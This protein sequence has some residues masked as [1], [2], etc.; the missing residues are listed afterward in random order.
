MVKKTLNSFKN[1]E[2]VHQCSRCGY[3]QAVCPVFDAVRSELAVARGKISLVKALLSGELE[4]TPTLAKYIE[5]CTGCGAC[6]ESCL[7]GVSVENI[8]LEARQHIAETLGLSLPKKAIVTAFNDDKALSF[9]SVLLN[10]YSFS[11]AGFAADLVPSQTP[12]LDKVKLLNAQLEKFNTNKHSLN[13][14]HLKKKSPLASYVYFPGCINKY[15]NPSVA[16]ST[17]DL[18]DR[19][20][21]DVFIPQGLLCC[22]MPAYISGAKKAASAL[23]ENNINILY[24]AVSES[25]R[26]IVTDC[27]SCS[28]ML[29]HLYKLFEPD[30]ECYNKALFIASVVKDV[31]EVLVNDVLPCVISDK[32]LTVTYHDPC[33]LR[34]SQGIYNEPRELIKKIKNVDLVEM[35]DANTC[36]GAAGSFCMTNPVVSQKIST[37]KAENILNTGAEIALTSC[38]SCKVGLQQGLIAKNASIPVLHP[39]E[40]IYK[41]LPQKD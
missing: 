13:S 28:Y 36:C 25:K 34:R 30:S 15:V 20:G 6:Q 10:L 29:K 19:A 1:S 37:K 23:A 7:S 35:K 14:L 18:L 9:A 21:M 38:P 31:S 8:F 24:E 26:P 32:A 11:K 17:L 12:F 16:N 27:G 40:L 41:L 3:C 2:S 33:H 22:G 4:F 39:V 5:L